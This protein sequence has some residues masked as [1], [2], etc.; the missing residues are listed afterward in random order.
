MQIRHTSAS[1]YHVFWM[2][3]SLQRRWATLKSTSANVGR[4]LHHCQ[5][6]KDKLAHSNLNSPRFLE[7][8]T[9]A[10]PRIL[11]GFNANDEAKLESLL[12]LF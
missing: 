7:T 5:C 9:Q 4:E 12:K 1:W 10:R 3:Q 8:S 2:R 6:W 11:A